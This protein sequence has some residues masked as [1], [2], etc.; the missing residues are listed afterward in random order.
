ME[1]CLGASW[2][3]VAALGRSV[4]LDGNEK[5]QHMF[6]SQL[7][8]ALH[9]VNTGISFYVLHY[10]RE[11]SRVLFGCTFKNQIKLWELSNLNHS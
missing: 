8:V 10:K 4:S 7:L 3:K 6:Y 1:N 9:V 5:A 11:K 2:A